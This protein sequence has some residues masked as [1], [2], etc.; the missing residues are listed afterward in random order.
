MDIKI[1]GEDY[2]VFQT[3]KKDHRHFKD[4][5]KLFTQRKKRTEGV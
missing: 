5:M 2:Q 1:E 3:L 4:T